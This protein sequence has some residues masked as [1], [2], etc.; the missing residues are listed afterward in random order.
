MATKFKIEVRQRIL[1][2]ISD[3]QQDVKDSGHSQTVRARPLFKNFGGYRYSKS[4]MT[5]CHR[6]NSVLS[7]LHAYLSCKSYI[8][9]GK[10]TFIVTIV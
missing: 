10:L 8:A 7:M 9:K 4:Q 2:F 3:H 5:I 6:Q 1:W